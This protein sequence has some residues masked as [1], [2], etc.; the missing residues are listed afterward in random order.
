MDSQSHLS[1]T[2]L[3]KEKLQ[4]R[5]KD[6]RLQMISDPGSSQSRVYLFRVSD[7][8]IAVKQGSVVHEDYRPNVIDEAL[9]RNIITPYLNNHVAEVFWCG[10]Y[11][12]RQYMIYECAGQAN[13]HSE[14]LS[15][16]LSMDDVATVWNDVLENLTSMWIASKQPITNKTVY[17]RDYDSRYNRVVMGVTERLTQLLPNQSDIFDSELIINGTTY[18][19]LSSLFGELSNYD[20]PEFTVTCHGDPQPSNIIVNPDTLLWQLIDWE[21]SSDGHDW[22]MMAAHLFGWWLS[23]TVKFTRTPQMMHENNRLIIDYELIQDNENTELSELTLSHL[24]A[25]LDLISN[26]TDYKQFKKFLSLLLLGDI[27]FLHIWHRQ[28]HLPYLLAKAVE[29]YYSDAESTQ[30]GIL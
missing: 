24:E 23:R 14:V 19:S 11:K 7:K 21:W 20:E 13:L 9:K 26:K 2:K 8:L 5:E 6:I 22:R 15:R 1:V 4:L 12:N 28:K 16:N 17:A 29:L 25:R 27:R 10:N 30:K 18:P 3:L